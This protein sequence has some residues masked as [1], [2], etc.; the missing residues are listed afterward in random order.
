[1][2][3]IQPDEGAAARTDLLH[4]GLIAPPPCVGEGS[5]IGAR[6]IVC[7]ESRRFSRHTA[8]PVDDGAEDIEN[9]RL[10]VGESWHGAP[11][12]TAGDP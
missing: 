8:A 7:E 1:M 3:D 9:K 12:A 11:R 4:R 5:R 2:Q 6:R 10:N